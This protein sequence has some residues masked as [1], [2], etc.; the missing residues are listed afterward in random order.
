MFS[1]SSPDSRTLGMNGA[2]RNARETPAWPLTSASVAAMTSTA[3]P[4]NS[5]TA[6]MMLTGLPPHPGPG[7]R[8]GPR[9]GKRRGSAGQ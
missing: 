7:T 6:M 4:R 2:I 9:R 8:H 5:A 1:A 3:P